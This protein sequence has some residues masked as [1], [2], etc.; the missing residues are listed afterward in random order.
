MRHQEVAPLRAGLIQATGEAKE[1]LMGAAEGMV[2]TLMVG[3]V[4][5]IVCVAVGYWRDGPDAW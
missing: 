1:R 3:I 4:T 2:A 5:A